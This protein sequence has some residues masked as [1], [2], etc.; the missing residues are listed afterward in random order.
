M[1]DILLECGDIDVNRANKYT[2][3]TALHAAA[4]Q[5]HGKVARILLKH[6]ANPCAED[7]EGRT[8]KDYATISENIWPLFAD[9]DLKPT[10]KSELVEKNIIRK[11]TDKEEPTKRERGIRVPGA[12]YIKI[13]SRPGS[14]YGKCSYNPL[15]PMSSRESGKSLK[16]RSALVS[17]PL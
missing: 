13:L 3:W 2:K 6:G 10:S 16:K 5:E 17:G 9:L 7:C 1:I 14:S 8:P 4:F 15:R 11:L 12:P